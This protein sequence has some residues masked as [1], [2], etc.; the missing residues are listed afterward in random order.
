[1]TA[2]ATK[3]EITAW[4]SIRMPGFALGRATVASLPDVKTG[5]ETP[6]NAPE[7]PINAEFEPVKVDSAA[8]LGADRAKLARVARRFEIPP[9]GQ[10]AGPAYP[11]RAMR[12]EQAA[13]YLSMSRSMWLKL[14]DE[15]K[16]PKPVKIGAMTTWDRYDIDDAYEDLKRG[17]SEPT[18]NTVHRRLRELADERRKKGSPH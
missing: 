10:K 16:M 14:V 8:I 9:P 4:S 7:S 15:G 2:I 3:A 5:A 11:P 1:M 6:E 13:D 17:N 12:A 18:E